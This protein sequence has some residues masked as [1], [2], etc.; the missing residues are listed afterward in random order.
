M[1]KNLSNLLPT[2]I[3]ESK[4][5]NDDLYID[6]F[7]PLGAESITIKLSDLNEPLNYEVDENYKVS[8]Q[9]DRTKAIPIQSFKGVR[10]LD[11]EVK[12]DNQKTVRTSARLQGY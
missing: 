9:N 11:V 5:N 4:S 7:L 10:L 6:L 12:L 2:K 3:G 1:K 8:F